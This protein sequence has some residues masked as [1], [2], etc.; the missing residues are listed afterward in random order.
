M[1][2]LVRRITEL[3]LP[4][5]AKT[6]G[7]AD[8]VA[9]I[10]VGKYL[11]EVT[12]IANEAIAIIRQWLSSVGLQLADQKTEVVLVTSRKVAETITIRVGDCEI[13]SKPSLRY[14]GVQIDARLRFQ[15][16]LKIVGEKAARVTS[17]LSRIMPNIGGPRQSRRR[18]LSTVV[19]SILLYAAP[20]WSEAMQTKSYTRH[21]TTTYRRASLR[22]AHA[23]RT[24]SYEA[25]CVISGMPPIELIVEER[26]RIYRR[27][28]ED[29]NAIRRDVMTEE[30][31]ETT[32]QWQQRW[33][34]VSTG[35]WTHRLIPNLEVWLKRRGGEVNHYVTQLLSGH[36][37]FLAY[38]KR[39]GITDNDLCPTCPLT[40]ENAEHVFFECPRFQEERAELCELLRQRLTPENI[41]QLMLASEVNWQAV[42]DYA[43]NTI[44][45]L[46]EAEKVRLRQNVI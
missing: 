2:H 36:G 23:F 33:N 42:A 19:S 39:F 6:V 37:C 8:D 27:L 1:E 40:V 26:A 24:V 25:V 4:R 9:V 45:T 16:H 31:L 46:R 7:F 3:Q 32:A 43:A 38:Q 10:A 34:T 41:V 5:G 28:R 12:W 44:K 15:E 29:R 18:L 13:T 21:I 11:A 30:Q 17:A 20:T 22:V 14:L 35:R